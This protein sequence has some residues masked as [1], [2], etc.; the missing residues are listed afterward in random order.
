MSSGQSASGKVPTKVRFDLGFGSEI[1]RVS[2][3][4]YGEH[5]GGKVY[6]KVRLDRYGAFGGIRSSAE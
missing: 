6:A 4:F 2:T 1:Y 3:S 5:P